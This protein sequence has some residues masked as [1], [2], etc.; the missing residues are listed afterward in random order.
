MHITINDILVE[1]LLPPT[2]AENLADKLNSQ[3]DEFFY[4]P[5]H[6]PKGTGLSYIAVYDGE[7]MIGKL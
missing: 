7:E 2:K 5:V 6:C 1:T 3:D 4:K